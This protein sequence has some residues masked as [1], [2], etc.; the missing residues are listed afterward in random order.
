MFKFL[1]KSNDDENIGDTFGEISYSH[2]LKYQSRLIE[3]M[4][5]L[6][7]NESGFMFKSFKQNS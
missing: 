4:N 3:G 6:I 1:N 7:R 5:Y 2:L